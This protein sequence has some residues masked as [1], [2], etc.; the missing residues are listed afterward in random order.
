MESYQSLDGQHP[1]Y[2]DSSPNSSTFSS[3]TLIG[4]PNRQVAPERSQLAPE[5]DSVIPDELVGQNN[6]F[7]PDDDMRPSSIPELF[8]YHEEDLDFQYPHFGM[9]EQDILLEDP[10]LDF[11]NASYLT[12]PFAGAFGLEQENTASIY[13]NANLMA[14]EEPRIGLAVEEEITISETFK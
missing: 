11:G 10:R 12:N 13:G 7:I 6:V 4:T 9:T 1:Q 14:E 2:T 8:E 3:H 5:F